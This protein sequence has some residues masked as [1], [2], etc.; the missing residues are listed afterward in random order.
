MS[1]WRRKPIALL[2]RELNPVI[3]GIIQYYHKFWNAG[4]RPVWN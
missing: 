3:K 4:M 1:H 2:A